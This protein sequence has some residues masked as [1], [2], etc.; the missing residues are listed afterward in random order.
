MGFRDKEREIFYSRKWL[1]R[2]RGRAHIIATV[3]GTTETGERKYDRPYVDA[4]FEMGDCTNNISLDFCIS[5]LK[6]KK[7]CL[8]IQKK[9]DLMAK[10]FSSFQKSIL[11]AIEEAN[12]GI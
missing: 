1:N 8:K 2:K 6:D 9:L 3:D 5:D 12:G 10:T 11:D 4:Y 7:E